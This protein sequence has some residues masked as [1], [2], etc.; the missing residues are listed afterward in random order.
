MQV[1]PLPEWRSQQD[2]TAMILR[3]NLATLRVFLEFCASID[4]VEQY[5]IACTVGQRVVS[6]GPSQ[7]VRPSSRFTS[8]S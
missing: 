4:G 2:I 5:H 8:A 1:P 6:D 3:T 7:S